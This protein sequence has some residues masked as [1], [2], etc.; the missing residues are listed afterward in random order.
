M[1]SSIKPNCSGYAKNDQDLIPSP[2]IAL[3]HNY[4]L[5]FLLCRLQV[6]KLVF[7]VYSLFIDIRRSVPFPSQK[8]I[9]IQSFSEYNQTQSYTDHVEFQSWMSRQSELKEDIKKVCKEYGKSLRRDVPLKQF[10]YDPEHK[11]LFCRNA[12]VNNCTRYI[13]IN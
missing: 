2:P 3:V 13:N 10:M 1:V 4:S 11:L 8:A 6:K 5:R 12:K 7:H 9:N